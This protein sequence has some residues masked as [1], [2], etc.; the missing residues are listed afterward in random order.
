[1]I[2]LLW[3]F[4]WVWWFGLEKKRY[5]WI[6]GLAMAALRIASGCIVDPPGPGWTVPVAWVPRAHTVGVVSLF[7]LS[8]LLVLT[9]VLGIRKQKLE[10]WLALPALLARAV[11]AFSLELIALHIPMVFF[12]LG[13]S[14]SLGS[15]A[16]LVGFMLTGAL[17]IR[18]FMREL[19]AHTQLQNEVHNAQQVQQVLVPNQLEQFDNFTVESVYVPA[20]EVGG[21]FFQVIP[22]EDGSLLAVIGDVSGKGIPAAMVVA[23]IVGALRTATEFTTAPASLM[24]MLN[25]RL[26][27]RMK[28]GFATCMIAHISTSGELEIANAAHLSPYL[29][30][31]EIVL[32][33]EIPLGI[34]HSA[35]YHAV[36]R[37]LNPGDRLTFVSDGVVEARGEQGELFGFERTQEISQ[38]PAQEIVDAAKAHGQDDDITVLTVCFKP[39]KQM[40][41][42]T[43]ERQANWKSGNN[44][45]FVEPMPTKHSSVPSADVNLSRL[46]E[47][48]R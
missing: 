34:S 9:A 8:A 30:G 15:L 29:N 35:A 1:M 41:E 26:F 43:S 38:R 33:P 12:P 19:K 45:T 7:A 22:C 28:S 32:E 20:R 44:N 31:E 39:P 3:L 2:S 10:G 11:G 18:R 47:G 6:A 37:Q 25:E 36:R 46:L 24:S 27:G 21:D 42:S 48:R 14:F 23:L 4:V 40:L 5:L 17:L 13:I 16:N